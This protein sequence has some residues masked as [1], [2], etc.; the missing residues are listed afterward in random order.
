MG[1]IP[2]HNGRF[3]YN[4][5]LRTS[6][7]RWHLHNWD[8]RR[9]LSFVGLTAERDKYLFLAGP[10]LGAGILFVAAT[11]NVLSTYYTASTALGALAV[12]TTF[13][14]TERMLMYG[15]LGVMAGAVL[16]DT[17]QIIHRAESAVALEEPL[18]EPIDQSGCL[19]VDI[20][21]MFEW[22]VS[23][24]DDGKYSK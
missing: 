19:M 24:L 7:Q 6:H 2:C 14:V 10:L 8:V 4:P 17:H 15:T 11:V 13:T 22:L 21:W 16:Y 12:A 20:L 3:H 5:A 18:P 1:R 9:G 23:V